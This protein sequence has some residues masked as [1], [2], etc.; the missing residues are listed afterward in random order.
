MV[1]GKSQANLGNIDVSVSLLLLW[2]AGVGAVAQLCYYFGISGW[3]LGWGSVWE[4]LGSIFSASSSLSRARANFSQ[5]LGFAA[6]S[7]FSLLHVPSTQRLFVCVD[8]GGGPDL[9]CAFCMYV[10]LPLATGSDNLHG[11]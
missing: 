10:N 8:S 5:G 11:Q 3:V 2:W 9:Q 7:I 1:A 4:F 6:A